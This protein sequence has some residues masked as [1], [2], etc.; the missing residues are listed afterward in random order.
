[1]NFNQLPQTLSDMLGVMVTAGTASG[2]TELSVRVGGSVAYAF[3][4]VL[5]EAGLVVFKSPLTR[6]EQRVAP[7]L[8]A[9]LRELGVQVVE[10]ERGSGLMAKF[11]MD[12][13]KAPRFVALREL[14]T[15]A[16]DGPQGLEDYAVLREAMGHELEADVLLALGRDVQGVTFSAL[17]TRVV[18]A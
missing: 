12:T 8:R 9:A 1:M 15:A 5:P 18:A 11:S 17:F 7:T 10:F 4:R 13:V 14:T 16:Y 6:D 2:A 3:A